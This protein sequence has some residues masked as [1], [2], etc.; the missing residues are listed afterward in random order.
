MIASRANWLIYDCRQRYLVNPCMIS[1]HVHRWI[2]DWMIHVYYVYRQLT[3]TKLWACLFF[4]FLITQTLHALGTGNNR[5]FVGG[6][7]TFTVESTIVT[8]NAIWWTHAW[9]QLMFT[10]D[11]MT[12]THVHRWIHDCR[13]TLYD[14]SMHEFSSGSA[15]NPWLKLTFT[16][17]S[18]IATHPNQ[19]VHVCSSLYAARVNQCIRDCR[20]QQDLKGLLMNPYCRSRRPEA[21]Y[22]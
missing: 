1:T 21:P 6:F 2:H 7:F 14:E 11:S 9:F 17:E 12:E 15:T 3:D 22:L 13:Q 18:M 8:T 10:D 4:F 5:G 16:E 20:R 19:W